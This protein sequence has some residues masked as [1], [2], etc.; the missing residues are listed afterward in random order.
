M[1]T[2]EKVLAVVVIGGVLYVGYNSYTASQE[3]SRNAANPLPAGSQSNP[4]N[5]DL[6]GAAI[7]GIVGGI[8]DAV[9]SGNQ[10]DSARNSQ[11]DTRNNQ[12][13]TGNS[14]ISGN[15]PLVTWGAPTPYTGRS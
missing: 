9:R 7:R 5:T 6:F 14:P 2:G 15:Q 12:T 10:S 4:S 1:T 8:G 11:T 3:A 13:T